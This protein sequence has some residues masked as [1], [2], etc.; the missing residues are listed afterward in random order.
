[1]L[2]DP[3]SAGKDDTPPHSSPPLDIFAEINL[4]PPHLFL[5]HTETGFTTG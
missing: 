1:M 3:Y 5:L 2:P 4:A